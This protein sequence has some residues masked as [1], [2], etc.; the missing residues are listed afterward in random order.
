[1]TTVSVAS[2]R[3]QT[4]VSW[5]VRSADVALISLDGGGVIGGSSPHPSWIGVITRTMSRIT[6]GL[7]SFCPSDAIRS[8][9]G[10]SSGT[11]RV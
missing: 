7:Q 2:E 10:C 5:V 3:V 4:V 6:R 8:R 1:L 11:S 9:S